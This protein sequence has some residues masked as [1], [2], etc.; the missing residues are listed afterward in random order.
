MSLA[1][2][3][4]DPEFFYNLRQ[5]TD[6]C[7][8]VIANAN[9][10]I[11]LKSLNAVA[12]NTH[13]CGAKPCSEIMQALIGRF[14]WHAI[15]LLALVAIVFPNAVLVL[16]RATALSRDRTATRG[17]EDCLQRYGPMWA[18]D[19]RAVRA[20]LLL[21]SGVSHEESRVHVLDLQGSDEE[22]EEENAPV[23]S[24]KATGGFVDPYQLRR[25]RVVGGDWTEASPGASC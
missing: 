6:L 12:S 3:G 16:L 10:S 19:Q 7:A 4:Q 9:A 24:A 5:H 1:V 18:A 22:E 2:D 25:R 17:A 11:L 21:A 14:T 23:I 15:A 20:P 13:A 8:S